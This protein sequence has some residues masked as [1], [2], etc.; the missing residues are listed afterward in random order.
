V[1]RIAKAKGLSR[2]S[3]LDPRIEIIRYEKKHP[4]EMIHTDIRKLGRSQGIGPRITGDRTGRSAPCSRKEDG[5]GWEYLLLAV[6]DH[7]LLH[8]EC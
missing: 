5:K 1:A 6:D 4:G 7:S 8:R 2:L 3:A